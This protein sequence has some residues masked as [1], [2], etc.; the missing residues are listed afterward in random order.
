MRICI[1]TSFDCTATGVTGHFRTAQ[2][3][4]TDR[5]GQAVTNELEWNRSRNQQRNFE[6]LLQLVG[7]YTQPLDVSDPVYDAA[8]QLWRFEFDVEFAG[9]FA[10]ESDSIGL[11]KQQAQGVPMI[12]GL[13]EDA[14]L[15]R[16][17][18]S[19]V[20]IFFTELNNTN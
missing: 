8:A 15:D 16:Q 7:L 10:T 2:L 14:L 11:L 19:D 13:T 20:N 4:L 5:A 17:L 6:T 18:A 12:V 9:I 1:A 3:P